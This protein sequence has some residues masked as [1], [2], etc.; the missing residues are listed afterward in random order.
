M[1]S[2]TAIAMYIGSVEGDNTQRKLAQSAVMWV[3]IPVYAGAAIG[4]MVVFNLIEFWTGSRTEVSYNHEANGT[5]VALT[6]SKGQAGG[7]ADGVASGQDRD[8]GAVRQVSDREFE[9]RN[10]EGR[11]DGK[12]TRGQDG[13]L[14]LTDSTGVVIQNISTRELAALGKR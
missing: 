12:I 1:P 10:P 13:S 5:K 8:P 9:V 14:C 11:L 3:F 6:P 2:T 4:D 7:Y